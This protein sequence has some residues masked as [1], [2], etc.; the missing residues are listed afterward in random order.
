MGQGYKSHFGSDLCFSGDGNFLAVGANRH[1]SYTGQ[2]QVYKYDG[3]WTQVGNSID[4]V[5]SADMAGG[6]VSMNTDGT[7]LAVGAWGH[8]VEDIG[9][10]NGQVRVFQYVQET[11]TWEQVGLALEGLMA[12]DSFGWCK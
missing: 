8:D 3:D 5:A 12:G 9:A 11:N 10:N 1:G 7:I 6:S 4:G 2:V